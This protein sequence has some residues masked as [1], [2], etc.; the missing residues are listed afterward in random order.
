MLPLN[1]YRFSARLETPFQPPYLL[2]SK[3]RGSLGWALR[4][5]TCELPASRCDDNCPCC[6]DSQR[7]VYPL[8]FE[9]SRLQPNRRGTV[10]PGW[11]FQAVQGTKPLP[12]GEYLV[13]D[14]TLIGTLLEQLPLMVAA[15]ERMLQYG[16]GQQGTKKK[17]RARLMRVTLPDEPD[18]PVIWQPGQPIAP[19]N[20]IVP[21]WGDDSPQRLLLTLT[22]PLALQFRGQPLRPGQLTAPVFLNSLLRRTDELGQCWCPGWQPLDIPAFQTAIHSIALQEENCHWLEERRYSH[23]QQKKLP[24]AG[25]QGQLILTGD[26]HPF[27]PFLVLGEYINTGRKPAFGLGQYRLGS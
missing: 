22:S 8:I 15:V 3:L 10:P 12:A 14:L 6:Y 20:A 21:G 13:F 17:A 4:R 2:P 18:S 23:R 11:L 7:S 19:H 26:L 25:I 16:L 9:P 27:M 1:R 24:L 5:L